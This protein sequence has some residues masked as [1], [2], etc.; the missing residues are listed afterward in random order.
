M[1]AIDL[2]GQCPFKFFARHVLRLPEEYADEEG[3]TPLERGRFLHE[4]FE[5]FYRAWQAKGHGSI[6]PTGSSR[7]AR[8]SSRY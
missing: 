6:T 4:T 8:C 3:L 5:A 7:P 1:S 2:Y